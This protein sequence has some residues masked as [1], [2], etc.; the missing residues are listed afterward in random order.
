MT[1]LEIPALA[2]SVVALIRKRVKRPRGLPKI[3]PRSGR[4]RWQRKNK[5]CC[6]LGLCDPA[7]LTGVPEALEAATTLGLGWPQ[8]F[9]FIEWWDAL[10]Q[11]DARAAMDL[12]WG[13]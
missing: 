1:N 4:L 12:I 10:N 6:P 11:E 9:T 8:T 3:T 13:R 5:P 7:R 2:K